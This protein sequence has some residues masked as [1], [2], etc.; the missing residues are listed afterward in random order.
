MN[1]DSPVEHRA[2]RSV[3]VWSLILALAVGGCSAGSQAVPDAAA[4]QPSP[5]ASA[6]T[7]PSPT[8]SST[9]TASAFKQDSVDSAFAKKLDALCNGWN[10]FAS[11]HP[12]PGTAN[13]QAATVEELPKIGAWLDPVARREPLFRNLKAEFL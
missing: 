1:T 4:G 3:P 11:T 9:D 2:I 12:Y 13:P 5:N 6:A 7:T 10:S 8:P